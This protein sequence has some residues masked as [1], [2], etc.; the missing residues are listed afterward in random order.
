MNTI[1]RD[2]YNGTVT[3]SMSNRRW[4]NMLKYEKAYKMARTILRAKAECEKKEGMAVNDA[5]TYIDSL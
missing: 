3:I 5:L 2:N 1:I 4:Q